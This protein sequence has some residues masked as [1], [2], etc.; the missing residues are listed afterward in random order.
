MKNMFANKYT[1]TINEQEAILAFQWLS[2]V[3]D[4]KGTVVRMEV[5]DEKSIVMTRPA[6]DNLLALMNGLSA[7]KAEQK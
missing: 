6:Y 1:V 5:V 4:D 2:P 7:Q 3:T